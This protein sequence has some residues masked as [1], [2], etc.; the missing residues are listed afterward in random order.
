M[1]DLLSHFIR[2]TRERLNVEVTEENRDAPVGTLGLD[3]LEFIEYLT[4]LED[5]FGTTLD[6]DVLSSDPTLNEVYRLIHAAL[7]PGATP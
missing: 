7:H 1:D 4:D 2:F 5:E 3:S 6:L